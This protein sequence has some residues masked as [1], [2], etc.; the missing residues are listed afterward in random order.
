MR[1]DNRQAKRADD[2]NMRVH[3]GVPEGDHLGTMPTVLFTRDTRRW[4][5][6]MLCGLVES[7]SPA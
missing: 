7:S 3:I 1:L 4:T 6:V 2:D 5:R